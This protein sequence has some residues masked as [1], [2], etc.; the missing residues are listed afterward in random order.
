MYLLHSA[1]G[2][3]PGCAVYLIQGQ[4]I[5]NRGKHQFR[6][7]LFGDQPKLVG[8]HFIFFQTGALDLVDISYEK[9]SQ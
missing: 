6:N 7:N 9:S 4:F 5:R 2:I 1:F 3:S 8:R